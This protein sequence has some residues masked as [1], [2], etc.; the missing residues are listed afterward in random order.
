MQLTAPA[1]LR[2]L[3]L[4]SPALPVGGY[5]YSQGLEWAIEE[6]TAHDRP[7][8]ARW[9]H[10]ALHFNIGRFEA[11]V[12]LRLYHAWQNDNME[13]AGYWN[14]VMLRTR[15]SSELRAET[16]QMGYSL[17]R[18]LGEMGAFGQGAMDSL[19]QVSPVTFTAAFS[20]AAAKWRIPASEGLLGYLWSWLENQVAVSMKA[21]PL[22]QVAGQRLLNEVGVSIPALVEH[23]LALPDE[24]LC[25]AAPALAIASCCHET[26]YS[27]LFRS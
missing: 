24:R 8:V 17:A 13:Q 2:L 23:V 21:V 26:Q 4:A 22:G 5:S 7:S 10:D 11:P 18:L 19:E 20:F 1:L 25:N 3:Q 27:R 14:D 6:G 12:W 16:I 9:I 15:E